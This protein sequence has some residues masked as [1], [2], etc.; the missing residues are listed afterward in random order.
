MSPP[1]KFERRVSSAGARSAARANQ[2]V[3]AHARRG[4]PGRVSYSTKGGEMYIGG[5]VLAVIL[6]ILLLV[7]LF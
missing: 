5:G 4:Y 7:W 6:I 2:R 3:W 1:P